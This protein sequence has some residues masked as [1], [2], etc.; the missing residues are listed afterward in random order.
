ML[1]EYTFLLHTVLFIVQ[2][3]FKQER[4]LFFYLAWVTPG[5]KFFAAGLLATCDTNIQ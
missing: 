4:N 1:H 5:R 2:I 3:D